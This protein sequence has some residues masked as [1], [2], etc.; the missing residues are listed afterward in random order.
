M[1]EVTLTNEDEEKVVLKDVLDKS[2]IVVRACGRLALA[3]AL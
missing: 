3:T 1:P 2:G